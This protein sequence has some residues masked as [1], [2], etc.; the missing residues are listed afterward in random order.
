MHTPASL[1]HGDFDVEARGKRVSAHPRAK[2]LLLFPPIL[3]P[4]PRP[5]PADRRLFP[6]GASAQF[7]AGAAFLTFSSASF[8]FMVWQPTLM[9]ANDERRCKGDKEKNKWL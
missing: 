7:Q 2:R 4:R 3:W 5:R 1:Y 8:T 6:L 9:W